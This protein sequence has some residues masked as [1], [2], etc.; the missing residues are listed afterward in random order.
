MWDWDVCKLWAYVC[1]KECCL[2]ELTLASLII[3]EKADN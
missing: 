1:L 2:F 3:N